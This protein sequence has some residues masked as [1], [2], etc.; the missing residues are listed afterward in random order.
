MAIAI[1]RRE[2]ISV[3]G[4]VTL[5]WPLAVRAQQAPMPVIGFLGSA[6]PDDFATR[7][8]AFREGLKEAGYVEGQNV[9]IDYR[10]TEAKAIDCRSWRTNWFTV[11]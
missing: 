3:L 4:G 11:K 8:R 10:W 9:A 5:A 2:F 7:L 6:S 1:G